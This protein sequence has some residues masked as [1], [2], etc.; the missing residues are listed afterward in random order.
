MLRRVRRTTS[1]DVDVAPV[2]G[3]GVGTGTELADAVEVSP[4]D[5]GSVR[6]ADLD[7]AIIGPISLNDNSKLARD[8]DGDGLTDSQELEFGWDPFQWD[9]DGDG[10]SDGLDY[11]IGTNPDSPDTDGDGLSDGLEHLGGTDPL[12]AD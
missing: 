4:I 8:T 5:A 12:V 6:V 1:D 2:E 11:E 3:D 9:T 7:T 10:L